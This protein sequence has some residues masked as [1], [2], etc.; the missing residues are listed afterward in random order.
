MTA[1]ELPAD[2][3]VVLIGASGAGK[4]TFAARSFRLTEIL[5]SDAFRA[6]VAD[7]EADQGATQA[8]FGLLHLAARRR[9]ERNRLTVVDATN[10]TRRARAALVAVARSTGRPVIAIVLDFSADVCRMRNATRAARTVGDGVIDRQLAQ[11]RRSLGAPRGLSA[12]G[13]D[14]VHRFT[15]PLELDRASVVRTPRVGRRPEP[16]GAATRGGGVPR[17]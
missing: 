3:L 6:I 13:F 9:L 12:E 8:A 16:A 14:G 4:T 11:L 17:R 5:S 1:L 2:A 15:D 10:V 7:D